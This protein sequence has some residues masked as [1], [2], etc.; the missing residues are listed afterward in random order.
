MLGIPR[1]LSGLIVVEVAVLS[2]VV[3]APELVVGPVV[4]P[5]SLVLLLVA[6]FVSLCLVVMIPK[7]CL[8]TL[9]VV[10]IV[11]VIRISGESGLLGGMALM[12]NSPYSCLKR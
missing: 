6:L 5:V 11:D 1:T 4:P 2:L 9:T 10:F 8:I 7:C 12:G 3:V